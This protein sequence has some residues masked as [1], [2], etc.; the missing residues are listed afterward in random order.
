MPLAL[1]MFAHLA[2]ASQISQFTL[3]KPAEIENIQF[4]DAAGVI[5]SLSDYKGKVILLNFWASWC[6]PCAHEM[7]ALEQL[8]SFVGAKDV[9][10]LP[11]SI[12]S[13]GVSAVKKFYNENK[14]TGLPILVDE[15]GKAFHAYK[16]QAL[17]TSFVID[18]RGR[19]I[20]KIMGEIDW[21]SPETHDYLLRI[22]R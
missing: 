1:I 3:D 2:S 11:V 8:A 16:L 9:E 13:K 7:P 4:S 18:R 6:E 21:N 20:A 5:H 10:V 22:G 19:L 17:P 15:K 14:I 12:D